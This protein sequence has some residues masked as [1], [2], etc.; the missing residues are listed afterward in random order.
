[1]QSPMKK[2]PIDKQGILSEA[3]E[4]KLDNDRHMY[5]TEK[6]RASEAAYPLPELCFATAS[7]VTNGKV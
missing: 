5:T 6:K 4:G 7:I 2:V 1:M 3:E